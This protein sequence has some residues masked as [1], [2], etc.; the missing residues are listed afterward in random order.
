MKK[1]FENIVKKHSEDNAFLDQLF[2]SVYLYSRGIYDVKNEFIKDHLL[3]KD[4]ELV[5]S[6]LPQIGSE[7]STQSLI[8][9]FE[10]AIPRDEQQT[11]GAVYTPDVIK[12]YIVDTTLTKFIDKLDTVLVADISCGCGAFLY[13]SAKKLKHKTEQPYRDI[14]SQLYGLDI[15][16]N[17][18]QRAKILLSLLAIVEGEDEEGFSF[19][20]FEGNA[21]NFDWH[22][23]SSVKNNKG[24]D[25]VVGNPPYV[26]AK[27]IDSA[28]KKL[29][30]NWKVASSGNPDLYLPFFEIGMRWLNSNGVLGYITVNSFFKSVNA[31]GLRN[32]LSNNEFPLTIIN[33]GHEQIFEKRLTYTCICFIDKQNDGNVSYTKATSKD[34]LNKKSFNYSILNYNNLNHHRGWLLNNTKIV[35][36]INRIENAGPS[37]DQLYSIKNGIATLSNDVYI[38]KPINEDDSNYYFIKDK[39]EYSVEK[40]ICREII[41]PNILKTENE[42]DEIKEK[43][44]YPYTN[45]IAPLSLLKESKLQDKFPLAYNYLLDYKSQL[46]ERDKGNGDYGAWFA[47]GRTQALNDKGLKLLFPYMAKKPHFVFT[48]NSDMLIYCGYAIFSESEEELLILKRILESDVFDY[49]MKNTSK[50]Y[51]SGYYSYAKNYV[52]HFGV[53]ELSDREK[54]ELLSFNSKKRINQFVSDKYEILI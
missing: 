10:I 11:N 54:T 30:K 43:I 47:F 29:L 3:E 52:K 45:G 5:L 13:S 34:L 15:S 20:L 31:R 21:L 9:L 35:S 36:N 6:V 4:H 40:T 26:R 2:T 51:S 27:H 53:C 12:D 33:F 46:D 23:I 49:Y 37:L 17:S 19:N 38:F 16:S 18:L 25:I 7:L 14:F 28:S 41:K 42:I 32:Y 8:E 48:N 1:I 50:P 24:F 39:K 22:K 44:I